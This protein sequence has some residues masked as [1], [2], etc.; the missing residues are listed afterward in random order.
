VERKNTKED[1]RYLH[2]PAT[3]N[4][5]TKLKEVKA[6]QRHTSDLLSSHKREKEKAKNRQGGGT[7]REEVDSDRG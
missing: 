5:R 2:V 7:A 4:G 6:R 3:H 1:G